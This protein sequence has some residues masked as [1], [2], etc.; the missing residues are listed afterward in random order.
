ML[1]LIDLTY[2]TNTEYDTLL[3]LVRAQKESLGY[4]NWIK[5]SLE[6]I[7]VK[8]MPYEDHIIIDGVRYNCFKGPG[9]FFKIPFKT[10]QY[11]KKIN[12]DVILIQGFISPFQVLM[13]RL[14]VDKKCRLILQHHGEQPYPGLTMILHK[15]IN[16]SIDAYLF[17]SLGN[18]KEWIRRK[19]ISG[20]EKCYEIQ[21][22][23]TS[24][25]KQDKTTSKIRCGISGT[26]NFI[27]VGRLNTNKDPLTVLAG[28]EAYL[29]ICP[30]AKLY[31]IYQTDE[32]LAAVQNMICE[33]GKLKDAVILKGKIDHEELE[34]WYSASDFY[35]SGSHQEAC[36]F[37]LI[38]AMA[39]GCIPVV[40]NIPSFRKITNE[41][42]FGLLYEPGDV[43][44]L[45]NAFNVLA[46]IPVE[47]ES[48]SIICHFEK[49]LSFKSIADQ[50]YTLC[51][52]LA[53][54]CGL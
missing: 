42:E 5:Q 30:D 36:G 37:A 43:N 15:L 4:V 20:P 27:W 54:G 10:L 31:M 23:S 9:K 12:P 18:S 46:S 45:T 7:I 24:F 26:H 13:L 53:V 22:A 21:A 34:Y 6:V 11:L 32:L 49:K 29:K 35:I 19:V 1:K 17:T 40:T 28:F 2:H 50:L 14:L 33:H 48:R 44:S 41:G 47:E 51:R 39:C 16:K 38:E 52:Q 3:Q 25:V 8:H